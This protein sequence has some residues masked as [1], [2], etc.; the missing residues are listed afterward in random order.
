MGALGA[1]AEIYPQIQS[2][3]ERESKLAMI[4]EKIGEERG[5]LL[6]EPAQDGRQRAFS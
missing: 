3:A 5:P 6:L 1:I 4:R 2:I